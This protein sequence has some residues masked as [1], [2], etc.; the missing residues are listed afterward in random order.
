M[1]SSWLAIPKFSSPQTFL[2]FLN[3]EIES[4]SLNQSKEEAPR[5]RLFNKAT[6]V[7]K[8]SSRLQKKIQREVK[9]RSLDMTKINKWQEKSAK[10]ANK[11]LRCLD[12]I[13]A[14]S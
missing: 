1:A 14:R 2:T 6:R 8:K 10:Y 3:F 13:G 11:G 9:K 4:V 5:Q 12:E 7:N